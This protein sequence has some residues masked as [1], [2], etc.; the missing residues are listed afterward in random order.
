MAATGLMTGLMLLVPAAALNFAR[1]GPSNWPAVDGRSSSPRACAAE[2][3]VY[4]RDP[5]FAPPWITENEELLAE[6]A[7]GSTPEP[8]AAF[9]SSSPAVSPVQTIEEFEAALQYAQ[10]RGKVA[11]VKWYAPWCR[12]CFAMKPLYENVAQK[13]SDEIAEYFEIDAGASRVLC[14]LANIENMPVVH[15]YA[16]DGQE[17]VLDSTWLVESS[18]KFSTF[19]EGLIDLHLRR[20]R[21]PRGAAR[22]AAWAGR[23]RWWPTRRRRRRGAAARQ[24]E[25]GTRMSHDPR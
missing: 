1:P 8:K 24:E 13:T 5:R 9:A 17:M 3:T 12:A 18:A 6:L 25:E 15:L 19:S 20:R 4:G 22:L 23:G 21:P 14:S 10:S 2:G 11:A 16:P 7:A